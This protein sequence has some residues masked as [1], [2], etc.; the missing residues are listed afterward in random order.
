MN[1]L[2]AKKVFLLLVLACAM[3]VTV[4]PIYAK[5]KKNTKT[6][7][8][9]SPYEK[10][11]KGKKDEV[12]KGVITL[13][14]IEGKILFEFP[15]TLQNREMLLGSTVSEISD[16]GNALVGQ[17]IKKPLHI[18]FALRDSVMEMREVSNFA[19][20]PIFSTS[21]DESIK[22]AMKKGV[23]EPVMEG[24]KVMAYNA[25]STA[26]VFDMTDFLVSDNKRMAI[27]DPYGKKTM[28]GACVRRATF[29]KE[30][31]YVDQIK[32]FDDN[33]SVTSSLSYLQDL[34]YMG[35]VAIAYQEP[36]TVKVNRSFVLL[37]ETPEMMPR[38]ADPRIGYFTSNKEEIADDYD[39][40][41]M[42]TYAN[43]WNVYPKDV[44]AYKRGELVEPTQ[45]ILFYVDDAFPGEWKKGIHEGVLVWN[46]AFER[47]GFK[48]VMQVKDFPKD[49]PEFDP[50]NIKYNCINYAP[51]GIANAMGPSWIDPR[52]SQ[53]INA[54]VFVYHD[55]IQ[56]V[57]DMRFVQTA[58]VDPRVRTPK[59]PQ[60]VLDESLRYIIS[61]EV[62]HCLGLMHNMGSSFAYA[63]ESYR[64]PVFMKEHGTTPSIMDYARFN[65]I[66]QPEDKDVCLTPPVLG[67]YDYYAIKWGY[68]VFPEAK[69]TEE[70]VPYLESII[71]SKIGDL[72]YRYGKQQLGYGV[73]DPTSLSEDISND[74][75]KAG[76]YG[77]KN[78]KYILGNFNTWLN[79]KDPDF[80]YRDHLYDALVSQYVRYLNNAWANV[81]GFFINEHYV[82]D[83]Y[84]TSEV[85]PHDMQKRAVQFVLNELKNID[86]IDNPDV[87]KNLTFDGSMSRSI[88]KS[89]SKKI[90]NT[91]RVSLAAYRDSSAYSPQEYLDDIYTILWESTIKNVEPTESERI[92]Q[93]EVLMGI[94]R[95]AD[96]LTKKDEIDEVLFADLKQAAQTGAL[97]LPAN[98]DLPLFQLFEVYKHLTEQGDADC[99]V[100]AGHYYQTAN[101]MKKINEYAGFDYIYYVLNTSNNNQ[102]HLY[103]DL[104]TRIK[105]IVEKRKNSG[106]YAT[107]SHYEYLLSIIND[108][109]KAK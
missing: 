12:K 89:M 18:K 8:K 37:P 49:D 22:Q 106:S 40:V 4:E 15:L 13:H 86:W 59:L 11:F 70:E 25:D 64:D 57:N 72:E 38:M 65:Y 17:K 46:K 105:N 54:S 68:T 85:I 51:I 73:F 97:Q 52:N 75:M 83:P 29:K 66:A 76:A 108:F 74:A 14:K 78:L 92:L 55:V 41:K 48:N 30:L 96:P 87:V 104:L 1:K 98:T 32:S 23:G 60:D 107:R 61:H 90:L 77:I 20:R 67:T 94:I 81:G 99:C 10:I 21:K 24:F 39:G 36:V 93:T 63:T 62:G 34:L 33:I 103:F 53:I 45:P 5:K 7:K 50:A 2:V 47:I 16:N 100:D 88:L 28:F 84:N 31:S 79:D 71:K 102:N 56:L 109:E 91:K 69:T 3:L 95:N 9:E 27:F 101:A 6:T 26:V 82:G 35:I 58:Q 19:R 43:K 80:T 42:N 44:E